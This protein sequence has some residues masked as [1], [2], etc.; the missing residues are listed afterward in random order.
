MLGFSQMVTNE[1]VFPP[2]HQSWDRSCDRTPSAGAAHS[3]LV[4]GTILLSLTALSPS[5]H[6]SLLLQEALGHRGCALTS[7]L[8]AP[9]LGSIHFLLW[10]TNLICCHFI[11]SMALEAWSKLS[12]QVIFLLI[13]VQSLLQ[14]HLKNFLPSFLHT[15]ISC[16]AFLRP[17]AKPR[18]HFSS[19]GEKKAHL[20]QNH[21]PVPSVSLD[22][23]SME[24]LLSQQNAFR[25]C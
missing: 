9:P 4:E 2:L 6:T 23:Q 16:R 15:A 10:G 19:W 22:V 12:L 25:N 24:V 8:C 18:M 3:C 13:P 1:A 21:S 7:A 14:C 20:W 11:T 5:A 17:A